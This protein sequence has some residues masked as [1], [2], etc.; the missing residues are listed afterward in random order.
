MD[1]SILTNPAL[2]VALALAA[3]VIAQALARHLRVPGIVLLLGTGVVL[4]PD[5]LGII[6]PDAIGDTLHTLVGFAVAVI[7]FEGGMN[8]DLGRLR[9]EGRSIRR[10]VTWGALVT[11][12][13]GCLSAHWILRWDWRTSILFG[14]LVIVTGP[15]VITPLLR[16]IKVS[17][18]LAT[19]LEA[20]GVLVDAIGAILAIVALEVAI[21]PS[22]EVLAFAVWDLLSRLGFGVV[23]G[24]VGG[25]LIALLLRYDKVIPEGMEN[26]CALSLVLA[27]FQLSNAFVPESGIITV[28]MAGLAVGNVKTR[29]LGDLREFKE[30]LTVM[31]IG[32]LFVLLAADVRLEQMRSLGWAGVWTVLALMFLVRP[33]NVLVGTIGSDL[34]LKEKTFLSWIAPRGIVAAA[35][36]SL[37]ADTLAREGIPGGG[38]L[39][40][41]VFLVIAMTVLVQGLTGGFLARLLGV[42][43][44]SNTGTVILGANDLGRAIGRILRDSGQE[45]VFLEANVD[46]TRAAEDEKFRVLFGSGLSEGL[47]Q[48]AELDIRA[49]CIGVTPN[50]AVNLLFA[51]LARKDFKVPRAWIA[52]R[53]GH[54]SVTPK[55]VEEAG[56][57]VLF[58]EPRNIELWTLRLERKL[59]TV[60]RW[61]RPDKTSPLREEPDAAADDPDSLLLP[62]VLRRGGKALP[63]D[64]DSG[65]QKDDELYVLILDEKRSEAQNWLRV[66]GWAPRIAGEAAVDHGSVP[67]QDPATAQELE[68]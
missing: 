12:A 11:A 47:L 58:G 21:S 44:L 54:K 10:L 68:R 52:L 5:L 50:D 25:F 38:E 6:R 26:I 45:V 15:T 56:G 7:L 49:G 46:S 63:F 17:R 41:M 20:E 66:H 65:A 16:R 35:V 51:R 3:G 24:L 57:S 1:P 4:G 67:E 22:E 36:A 40:A 48:R 64:A 53:R 37:F 23:M 28:V 27:L 59:A 62:L 55:M 8:L 42:Q 60:E 43:R 13:G 61:Q 31:L 34:T 18:K 19:V 39:R 30:Q 32:M 14:T 33:L 9:R 29:A 2:I